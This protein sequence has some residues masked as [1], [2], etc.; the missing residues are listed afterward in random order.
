MLKELLCH[1]KD[2][3]TD[4]I[5][6][7]HSSGAIDFPIGIH[8]QTGAKV[9]KSDVAILVNENVVRFDVPVQ[10]NDRQATRESSISRQGGQPIWL[11]SH[12]TL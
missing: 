11:H 6:S 5:G 9:S 1:L 3:R 8:L 4:V 10:K 7:T 12:Q 2:L